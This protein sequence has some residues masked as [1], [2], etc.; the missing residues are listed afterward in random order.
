MGWDEIRDGMIEGVRGRVLPWGRRARRAARRARYLARYGAIRAQQAMGEQAA[1]L[2]KKGRVAALQVLK[3]QR[4]ARLPAKLMERSASSVLH[5]EKGPQPDPAWTAG[6]G[7]VIRA[8]LPGFGRRVAPQP[9]VPP[10]RA[11]EAAAPSLPAPAPRPWRRPDVEPGQQAPNGPGA[12]DDRKVVEQP[13]VEPELPRHPD[14]NVPADT[15]WAR[16]EIPEPPPDPL[17]DW[18]YYRPDPAEHQAELADL[19]TDPAELEPEDYG[20]EPEES[21][22]DRHPSIADMAETSGD[23]EVIERVRRWQE[24]RPEPAA[25]ATPEELAEQRDR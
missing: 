24:E 25:E 23:P 18:A 8:E 11:P 22:A 19:D 7:D 4:M 14:E 6:Y 9:L 10:S 20:A 1:E 2:R 3:L 16:H 5:R 17:D 13:E 15:E 21:W 12:D